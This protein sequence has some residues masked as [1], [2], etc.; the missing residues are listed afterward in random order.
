MQTSRGGAK[1]AEE[2]DVTNLDGIRGAID[3]VATKI[4]GA[5]KWSA[6]LIPRPF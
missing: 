3:D 1:H 6:T 5:P 4:R 2:E